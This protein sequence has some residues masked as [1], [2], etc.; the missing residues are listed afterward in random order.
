[1][2][3]NQ[4][5]AMLL[6]ACF[7]VI[8][9]IATLCRYACSGRRHR[10]VL[11]LIAVVAV[12][13]ELVKQYYGCFVKES[14]PVGFLPVHFSSTYYVMLLLCGFGRGRVARAGDAL[15]CVGGTF[16]LVCVLASPTQ[17]LGRSDGLL[18]G[19]L[20]MHGFAYHMLVLLAWAIV[21][22][23]GEYRPAWRDLVT[24]AVFLVLWAAV[25]VPVALRTGYNFAGILSAHV[26]FL[27]ALRERFGLWGYL[28]C[29]GAFALLFALLPDYWVELNG[30][31]GKLAATRGER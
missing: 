10:R 23:R 21:V 25:A 6:P 9:S 27:E 28:G 1:M 26:P 17:V 4:T 18:T 24:F 30:P 11:A 29:Y 22:A 14:Y 16:L 15:L 31:A 3:W 12:C 13:G 19:Y 7:V 2:G 8:V 20:G 5:W